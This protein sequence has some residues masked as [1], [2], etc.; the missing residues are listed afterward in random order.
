M[1]DYLFDKV[2]KQ[3]YTENWK[4]IPVYKQRDFYKV[5]KV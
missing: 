4:Q 3:L 2:D 1:L 5:C